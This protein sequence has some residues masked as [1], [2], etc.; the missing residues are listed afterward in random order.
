MEMHKVPP[1]WLGFVIGH[2]IGMKYIPIMVRLAKGK[3]LE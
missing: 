1:T 3:T 2:S